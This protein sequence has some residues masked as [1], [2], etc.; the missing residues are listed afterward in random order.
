MI[1]L[2]IP[3]YNEAKNI[4]K[5]ITHVDMHLRKTGQDFEIIIVDD[6]SPDMTLH[7]AEKLKNKHVKIIR[8][9][10]KRGLSSAVIDGFNNSSG[11]IL[12]VIDADLSHPPDLIEEMINETKKYDLVIASRYLT[13][14]S[15]ELSFYRKVVSKIATFLARPLTNV[16]DP[17]SGYFFL[18]KKIIKN[19]KL[20]PIGYK[21]L[22]EILV[23]AKYDPDKIKEIPFIFGKRYFGKSKLGVKVYA[24]YI[25]HLITLYLYKFKQIFKYLIFNY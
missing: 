14:D 10:G 3:T 15:H 19:V 2:I 18:N 9:L 21:I 7:I 6:N 8:R 5:L 25:M 17:L 12:G 16:K 24:A 1:S 20:N 13:K 22:L 4:I 23:K 11:H